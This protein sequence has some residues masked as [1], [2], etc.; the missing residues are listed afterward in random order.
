MICKLGSTPV[1][2]SAAL[3]CGVDQLC[4]GLFE[5]LSQ[6]P[7]QLQWQRAADRQ[8][9][10][11]TNHHALPDDVTQQRGPR[12]SMFGRSGSDTAQHPTGSVYGQEPQH[13]LLGHGLDFR[14]PLTGR[15]PDPRTISSQPG[16]EPGATSRHNPPLRGAAKAVIV[17]WPRSVIRCTARTGPDLS[18]ST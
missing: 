16:H 3:S 7:G 9:F 2:A 5:L 18:T 15:L 6:R 12:L 1:V 10:W 17:N 4:G 14:T 13:P 8:R 11:T